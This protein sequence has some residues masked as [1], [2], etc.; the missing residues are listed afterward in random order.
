MKRVLVFAAGLSLLALTSVQSA[1]AQTR[2]AAAALAPNKALGSGSAPITVEVFSDFQCPACKR[3][4]QETTRPLIDNYVASGK[5]YLVHRDFPLP[6]HNRSREAARWANAAA[7]IGKFEV[8]E[9]ALYNK[10]EIWAANGNIAS[11]VASV[12]S[13]AEMKKVRQWVQNPQLDAA[14]EKDMA[15]GKSRRVTQTPSLF[16]THNGETVALPPGGVTY[17]FLR[18]YLD[19]L[20]KH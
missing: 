15:L 6:I 17:A 3:L 9:E 4:F 2:V 10:Q 5:V 19:Y 1:G 18:Q 16:V 7:Q 11:V 13:L 8:V 14:I 20:L 12:L